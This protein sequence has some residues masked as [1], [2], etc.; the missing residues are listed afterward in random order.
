MKTIFTSL[1]LCLGMRQYSGFITQRA[2]NPVRIDSIDL[3]LKACLLCQQGL[4]ISAFIQNFAFYMKYQG[5]IYLSDITLIFEGCRHSLAVVTAVKYER[6]PKDVKEKQWKINEWGLHSGARRRWPQYQD[7]YSLS[8]RT[9]YHNISWSLKAA[10]FMFRLFQTLWN[11]TGTSTATL[12]RCLSN[13]R[14]MRL[15]WHPISLHGDFTRSYGKS[16]VRLVNRGLAL[17]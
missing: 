2:S 11:L 1:A 17:R 3:G 7:L 15:S 5:T 16:S 14:A 12:S 10:R 4:H 9:S 13:F 6:D 8:G